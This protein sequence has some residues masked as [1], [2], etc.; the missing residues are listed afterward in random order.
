[1]STEDTRIPDQKPEQSGQPEQPR[2]GIRER[3]AEFRGDLAR[4]TPRV[5]AT[6]ALIAVNAA[7]FVL[8]AVKGVNVLE[9]SIV[10]LIAWGANYGPRT[11]GGEWW[12]LASSFFLHGGIVHL[13]FNMVVLWDIGRF[14]ERLVGNASFVLIYLVCGL[15]GAVASI[16]WNPSVVSVGASGA[17]FGLYGVLLGFL[18]RSRH[19]IPREVLRRLLTSAIIFIAYNIFYG[20]MKTGIDNAAHLGGLAAGF[21]FGLVVAHP[22]TREGA[23]GRFKKTIAAA[24]CGLALLAGV[25]F[26]LPRSV[27]FQAELEAMIKVE[28][29]VLNAYNDAVKKSLAS[30]LSN[31]GF[32]EILEKDVLPPW[33][34]FASHFAKIEGLPA[35]QRK[36]AD[37]V[38]AYLAAR[39]EAWRMLADGLR[40]NNQ[41]TVEDAINMQR[42]AVETVN[43]FFKTGGD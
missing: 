1:M 13:A 19:A 37:A 11:T 36:V 2:P 33:H 31:D 35:E 32:A 15:F 3:L 30:E 39:E 28:S 4:L 26:I 40:W 14:V 43:A 16:A 34:E 9:P 6:P 29:R 8:M 12:R 10:H 5:W 25:A 42:N 41:K 18:A 7:V 24:G 22:L 23:R 20:F 38:G 21:L 27:D 17:V